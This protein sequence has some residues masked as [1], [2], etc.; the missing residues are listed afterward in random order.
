MYKSVLIIIPEVSY[1]ASGADGG[2]G[3]DPHAS[4]AKFLDK[5]RCLPSVKISVYQLAKS[6]HKYASSQCQVLFPKSLIP[7]VPI[8]HNDVIL[9]VW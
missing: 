3:F 7:R 6:L 9:P 1:C 8:Q 2:Y 5:F 4:Q